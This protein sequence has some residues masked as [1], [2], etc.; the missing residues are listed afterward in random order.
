MSGLKQIG[1]LEVFMEAFRM[2]L[3][4]AKQDGAHVV[5]YGTHMGPVWIHM[6]PH[7]PHIGSKWRLNKKLS[8]YKMCYWSKYNMCYWSKNNDTN[9]LYCNKQYVLLDT[10]RSANLK[11]FSISNG[12]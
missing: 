8:K 5:P 9:G 10:K 12:T 11:V 4:T 7:G 1:H 6:G 2:I 3:Q